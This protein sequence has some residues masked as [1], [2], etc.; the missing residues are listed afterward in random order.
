MQQ[1]PA[2]RSAPIRFAPSNISPKGLPFLRVKY[3]GSMNS[4][5]ISGNSCQLAGYICQASCRIL[6]G[7]V[8]IRIERINIPVMINDNYLVF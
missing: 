5:Y 8:T 7:A 6:I 2:K 3:I 1:D 4:K